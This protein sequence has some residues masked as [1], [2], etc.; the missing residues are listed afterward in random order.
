[1]DINK[2]KRKD[3]LQ[4]P[5]KKWDEVKTYRSLL[6]VPTGKKHSSGFSFIAAY[7]LGVFVTYLLNFGNI[8]KFIVCL[9]VYTSFSLFFI[10]GVLWGRK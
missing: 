5:S 10:F 3:L 2:L 7:L 8:D 1:M 9:I 6:L 4:L